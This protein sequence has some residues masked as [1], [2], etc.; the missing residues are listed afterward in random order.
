MIYLRYRR[1]KVEIVTYDLFKVEIVTYDLFQGVQQ[2]VLPFGLGGDL[3][4][5]EGK[6]FWKIPHSDAP[7]RIGGC[8]LHLEDRQVD[9]QMGRP[10]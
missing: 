5:D 2:Q 8:R 9:R 4:Q 7:Q 10:C 6:I 1:S 3:L